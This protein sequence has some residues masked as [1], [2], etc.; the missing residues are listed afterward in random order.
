MSVPEQYPDKYDVV[1]RTPRIDL[2]LALW[3]LVLPVSSIILIPSQKGTTP[4]YILSFLS[5][6][7]GMI[8][9]P[10]RRGTYLA[11]L[12]LV[13]VIFAI[14]NLAAQLGVSIISHLNFSDLTM[15]NPYE[16]AELLRPSLFTQSLYMIA[17]L[18]AFV[19]VYVF[20]R[21]EKHDRSAMAGIGLLALYGLYEFAF[22]ILFHKSGDF[23]SNRTFG[24]GG[25][26]SPGSA[27]QTIHLGGFTIER[28]K[29]LTGEP[30]MYAFTALPFFIYALHTK[31]NLLAA[32]LF[33]TL[34]LSTA[35]TAVLGLMIYAIGRFRYYGFKDRMI[36]GGAAIVLVGVVVGG[37]VVADFYSQMIVAK[38]ALAHGSGI[39]RFETFANHMT[40]FQEAPLWTKLFGVGFGYVRSTDMFSTILVNNGLIGFGVFTSLFAYPVVLLRSRDYRTVGIKLALIVIY[41]TMMASVPEYSYLSIWLFLGMAYRELQTQRRHGTP[42]PEIAKAV[43]ES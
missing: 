30:S 16:D 1:V 5:I 8:L 6:P 38:F 37:I 23:L 13:I 41:V 33:V 18:A 12:T 9:V 25:D 14:L 42:R 39:D 7:I 36:W 17:S 31:R 24:H 11:N 26:I 34:M 15:L 20:Y 28:L 3:L 29:S 27:F 40:F 2:F 19:F 22:Y 21:K 4:A 10:R 32:L 43:T 35:T